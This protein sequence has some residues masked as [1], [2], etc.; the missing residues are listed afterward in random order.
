MPPAGGILFST[1]SSQRPV[2]GYI[3]NIER[4][5]QALTARSPLE[6]RRSFVALISEFAPQLSVDERVALLDPVLLGF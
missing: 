1:F 5:T 2:N 3:T 6:E 4:D